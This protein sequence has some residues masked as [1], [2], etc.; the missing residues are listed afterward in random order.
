[1]FQ[2]LVII[3]V[4]C[5]IGAVVGGG[6]K[7]RS[8]K[9]DVDVPVLKSIHRQVLLGVVGLAIIGLG[10]ALKQPSPKEQAEDAIEALERLGLTQK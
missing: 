2:A 5:V 3:G 9:T 1:M 7:L 10:F 6:L 8:E 4:V